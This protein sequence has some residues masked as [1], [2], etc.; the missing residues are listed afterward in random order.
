MK[1]IKEYK[2]DY[3]INSSDDIKPLVKK[4]Q[5]EDRE[6]LICIGLDSKNKVN[7]LEVVTVGI[8]NSSLVH[9]REF[10]KKAIINS[11]NSVVFVH[12][13]PT[14]D[15]SPSSEDQQAKNILIKSGEILGI[16]VVDS[17]IIGKGS[18]ESYQGV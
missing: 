10:F 7:F 16:K 6:F 5:N 12:N 11:C 2:K 14:G 17:V 1:L 4:F 8:L 9:P 3:K 13:H 15:L 18:L